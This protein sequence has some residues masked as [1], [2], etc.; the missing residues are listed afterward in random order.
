MVAD[1]PD[2]ELV[3][4]AEDPGEIGHRRAQRDNCREQ[5][6]PAERMPVD[7]QQHQPDRCRDR[8][9]EA[10]QDRFDTEQRGAITGDEDPDTGVGDVSE[11]VRRPRRVETAVHVLVRRRE[12]VAERR[13]C[14]QPTTAAATASSAAVATITRQ[15]ARRRRKSG[16]T[17]SATIQMTSVYARRE[18][19]R[20]RGAERERDRPVEAIT[21]DHHERAEHR[22][23]RERSAVRDHEVSANGPVSTSTFTTIR[24]IAAFRNRSARTSASIADSANNNASGTTNGS[25][26]KP[27]T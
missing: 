23:N 2:H 9:R 24:A 25:P 5:R 19:E 18:R 1:D 14:A 3:G 22:D 6:G 21:G 10:L 11:L 4:A 8:P 27:R 15:A 26:L 20:G 16:I 13:H 7:E 12:R 17:S